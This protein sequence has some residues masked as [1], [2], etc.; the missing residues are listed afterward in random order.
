MPRETE[1][2]VQKVVQNMKDRLRRDESI[3]ET[4][5]EFRENAHFNM[6]A[7]YGLHRCQASVLHGSKL[8][9]EFGN[10]QEF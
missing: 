2:T 1:S 4:S 6:D 5:D 10:I 7:I 3:T 9:K 8:R